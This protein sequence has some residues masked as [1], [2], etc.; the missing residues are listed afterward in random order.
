MLSAYT[1]IRYDVVATWFGKAGH[2]LLARAIEQAPT[3]PGEFRIPDEQ[4]DTG[5]KNADY[6]LG[7]G[8]NLLVIDFTLS[9]PTRHLSQG[10]GQGV[11]SAVTKL[12]GKFEQV[13]TTLRWCDPSLGTKWQPLVVLMSPMA[14]G[15]ED[16][17]HRRLVK[18]S[19]IP[20]GPRELMICHATDFLDLV[21]YA[22][23]KKMSLARSVAKWQRNRDSFLDWWL[24]E[25]GAK[26]ASSKLRSGD[27][28]ARCQ[29]ILGNPSLGRAS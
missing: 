15:L 14:M 3:V 7:D 22:T 13:Y 6:V 24:Y 18:E 4:I 29:T 9:S 16:L 21:Q 2:P 19:I 27:V 25:R 23:D 28:V 1:G 17:V 8:R 26:R 10:R 5:G 12:A 11:E 20:D